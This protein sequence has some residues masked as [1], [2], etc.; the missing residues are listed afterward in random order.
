LKDNFENYILIK[1]LSEKIKN[2]ILFALEEANVKPP[3]MLVMGNL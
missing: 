3:K 1:F 2:M